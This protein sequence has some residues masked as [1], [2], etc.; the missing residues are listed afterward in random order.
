M[1]RQLAPAAPGSWIRRDGTPF[2]IRPITPAD[3]AAMVRFHAALSDETVRLRYFAH[4][5]LSSR[6]AHERLE[7][8]CR[9]DPCRER[10]LVAALPTGAGEPQRIVAVGRLVW[11]P[12]SRD[13]EFAVVVADAWQR[14]GLGGELLRRL[15]GEGRGAG[16]RRI[17]AEV[18]AGNAG[19]ERTA[20]HAGF[21][22]H[23]IAD[24]PGVLEAEL[25]LP[26]KQISRR[27]S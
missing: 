5:K 20:R 12:G 24:D 21:S 3:E 7:R 13:A 1:Q 11:E 14:H 15:V 8:I 18:L 10:V 9:T 16:M 27:R 4:L 2:V 17:R 26:G 6:T 19:M 25:V 23:A 22:L